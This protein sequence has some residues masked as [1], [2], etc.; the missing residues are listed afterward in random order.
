MQHSTP[1]PLET[2][3]SSGGIEGYGSVFGNV[4][5]GGDIVLPGAFSK[6]LQ[7]YK[8]SNTM[9]QMF[10]AHKQDQVPGK[11]DSLKEDSYGLFGKGELIDT[12]LGSDVR[13]LTTHKAVSGLSIGYMTKDY[14]FD[15][16]GNRLLKQIDLFEISIV[17]LAMNPKAKIT[18]A[19]SRLSD[20]FEYVPDDIDIALFKRELEQFLQLKGFG[21]RRAMLAV[22]DIFKGFTEVSSDIQETEVSSDPSKE[23][24]MS[25]LK[26]RLTVQGI[27]R[28]IQRIKA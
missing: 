16:E 20:N 22:A 19:K 21:R 4:D 5:F 7:E 10:W 24:E 11:W 18:Y 13:K 23:P 8:D 27:D 1:I 3:A 15:K 17:P 26:E 25:P 14:S 28:L 2:K 9:P 6:S 12:T